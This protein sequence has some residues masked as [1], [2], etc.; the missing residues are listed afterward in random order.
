MQPK[1]H[2][3]NAPAWIEPQLESVLDA[4]D[5]AWSSGIAPN[6]KAFYARGQSLSP[7]DR[8]KLLAELIKIDLEYRWRFFVLPVRGTKTGNSTKRP[9]LVED[10]AQ[11]YPELTIQ[12]DLAAEEWLVRNRFGDRPSRSEYF[13]RFPH[14]QDA[15]RQQFQILEPTV[16][17]SVTTVT[18]SEA[19]LRDVPP[20]ATSPPPVVGD[21]NLWLGRYQVIRQLGKGSFGQVFLAKDPRLD[22]QV[23]IKMPL[24]P[25]G[26][27]SDVRQELLR[28]ARLAATLRHPGLVTVYDV[29]FEDD[30][31]AIIM[32]YVAGGTLGERI[33]SG[34]TP[35]LTLLEWIASVAEAV[36]AAHTAGLVHRDIKPANILLDELN[37]PK[38]ADFGLALSERQL[39]REAWKVTGTPAYMAPEQVRGENHRLDGRADIWSLGVILYEALTRRHPFTGDSLEE[40]FSQ[41]EFR[42]PKP[43]RQV[44]DSVDSELERICLKCLSKP[45]T[46]RYTTAR[47]LADDLR[48]YLARARMQG[49]HQHSSDAAQLPAL[50]AP[51][52][53]RSRPTSF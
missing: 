9:R 26:A 2:A 52:P 44:V 32:E 30:R 37:Q 3:S 17:G 51:S 11:E 28:E 12:A 14:L 49:S 31:C 29:V 33:A 21:P 23:V 15:L 10:Y 45:V 53:C 22:R 34:T 27:A 43:P 13:Q 18:P 36:H 38:V 50:A 7:A 35:R 47:D 42:E 25:S 24:G 1:P 48:R 40:L 39:K 5:A 20:D 41:I 16:K 6:L 19:T 8:A 46:A 4:F